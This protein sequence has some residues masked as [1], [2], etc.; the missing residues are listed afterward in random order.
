MTYRVKT[1]PSAEDDAER[2]YRWL[3]ERAP[4]RAPEWFVGLEEAVGSLKTNPHR[5]PLAPE[6]REFLQDIHQLLYGK[7]RGTYRILFRI[8]EEA[9]TVEVL[10]IRHASRKHLRLEEL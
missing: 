1:L 8:V 9:A 6:G 10:H 2:I 4:L 3:A 7:R 5:C